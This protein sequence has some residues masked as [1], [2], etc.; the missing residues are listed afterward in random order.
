MLWGRFDP[1]WIASVR[2]SCLIARLFA[3]ICF[4]MQAVNSIQ[5]SCDIRTI[6]PNKHREVEP[7]VSARAAIRHLLNCPF[8]WFSEPKGPSRIRMLWMLFAAP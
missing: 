5:V 2:E 3:S 8:P 6:F 1:M 4:S 7:S